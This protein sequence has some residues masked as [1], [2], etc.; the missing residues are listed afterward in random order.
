MKV[1]LAAKSPSAIM[2]YPLVLLSEST[3]DCFDP[4]IV[5]PACDFADLAGAPVGFFDSDVVG[6][7]SFCAFDI[8]SSRLLM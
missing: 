5:F 8:D 1:S 7:G 2:S 3:P 4:L 6:F